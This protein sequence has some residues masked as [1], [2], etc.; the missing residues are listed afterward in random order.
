M[1]WLEAGVK[2]EG[3]KKIYEIKKELKIKHHLVR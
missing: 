3:V 1:E 2:N